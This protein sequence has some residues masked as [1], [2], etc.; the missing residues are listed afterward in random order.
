MEGVSVSLSRLSWTAEGRRML[1]GITPGRYKMFAWDAVPTGAYFDSEF[2]RPFEDQ[3]KTV[4]VEK[5]DYIQAQ[6]TLT[7]RIEKI[8]ELSAR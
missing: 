3:S 8:G 1:Q 6:I 7:Q 2:L 5:N 4:T